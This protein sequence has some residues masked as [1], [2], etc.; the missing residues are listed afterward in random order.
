M[1]SFFNR[2]ELIITYDVA[3]Q[4]KI[5]DILDLNNVD[6]ALRVRYIY[7][8]AWDGRSS[9]YKFYV[10]KKNLDYARYLIKDVFR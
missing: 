4:S 2:K 1:V 6:Y 3:I 9:E 10:S 5:R 7:P 8:R